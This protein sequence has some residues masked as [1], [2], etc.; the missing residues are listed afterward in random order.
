MANI[1]KFKNEDFVHKPV[2]FDLKKVYSVPL[3]DVSFS[4]DFLI[5]L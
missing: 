3:I 2:D 5:S 4:Y 1:P